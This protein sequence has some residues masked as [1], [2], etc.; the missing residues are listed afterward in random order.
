MLYDGLHHFK[1]HKRVILRVAVLSA[2]GQVL[3]ILTVYFFIRALSRD[4]NFFYVLLLTPVVHLMSML[5]SINGLGVREGAFVYFFKNLIGL[6]EASALAI[7][8]LFMLLLSSVLGGFIYMA[9][10]QYHF[11]IR[12]ITDTPKIDAGETKP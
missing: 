5:P 8:F 10:Q 11:R 4:I 2:V 3:G 12:E 1:N 6:H 9:C 7:L